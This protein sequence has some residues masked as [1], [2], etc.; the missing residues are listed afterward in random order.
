MNRLKSIIMKRDGLTSEEADS[1][2]EEVR[3]MM[4]D[5]MAYGDVQE[6]EDIFTDELGLEPDYIVDLFL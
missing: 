2:L 5:A 6:A 4:N 1:L 3:E